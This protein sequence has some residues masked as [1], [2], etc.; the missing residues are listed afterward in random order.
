MTGKQNFVVKLNGGTTE[1][2]NQFTYNGTGAKT[3]NITPSG[4][5]AAN[6]SHNHT[7]IISKGRVTAISGNTKPGEGLSFVECYSNGYP[8]TY[9]NVLQIQGT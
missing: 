3:V 6:S 2:T 5:G 8:T 9:G 4:I 7:S 1:G